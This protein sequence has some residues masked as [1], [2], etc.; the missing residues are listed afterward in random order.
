MAAASNNGAWSTTVEAN[1]TVIFSP[2]TQWIEAEN[3]SF[4]ISV[5]DLAGNTTTLALTYEA[6]TYNF[7]F[8]T[9][10]SGIGNLVDWPEAASKTG[11]AAGDQIC[12]TIATNAGFKG[13]FVAWLSDDTNDAYCR[14]H[15][16]G[17]LVAN[18]CDQTYLPDFAGPWVRTDGY[19]FSA[20]IGPLTSQNQ[21]YTPL[22]FDETGTAV[23]YA[24][25][26]YFYAGTGYNGVGFTGNNCNNWS[27]DPSGTTIPGTAFGSPYNTGRW[28]GNTF[29]GCTTVQRLACFES[30]AGIP[31]PQLSNFPATGKKVFVTSTQGYGDLS[32]WSDAGGTTGITA[33]DTICRAR[34]TAAGLANAANYKAW[35]STDGVP[36]PSRLVSDGPFVRMDGVLIANNKADLLDGEIFTGISVDEFG[37]YTS[38]VAWT[39]TDNS[40]NAA[41]DNCSNWTANTDPV[42]GATL[43]GVDGNATATLSTHSWSDDYP[44]SPCNS[45]LTH[46]YCFED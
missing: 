9:S 44:P 14:V 46:L 29:T 18:N 39:G 23:P 43:Y 3:Q 25:P 8:V 34:A 45:I 42:S 38:H 11:L 16:L 20:K 28:S 32:T 35:L 4:N 17:G 37:N 40:G 6:D 2:N 7:A 5:K 13:T 41:T 24:Q 30:G 36:A 22:R 1:D 33:G 26:L 10:T 31:L 21:I 27:F 15:R 12:Q 19:P